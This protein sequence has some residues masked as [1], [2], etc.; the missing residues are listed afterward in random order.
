MNI[1]RKSNTSGALHIEGGN[2]SLNMRTN[3]Y[4]NLVT[5]SGGEF[6]VNTDAN[7]F[8]LPEGLVLTGGEES[9]LKFS[10]RSQRTVNANTFGQ[11]DLVVDVPF[12]GATLTI[13]NSNW[14]HTGAVTYIGS[15]NTDFNI[16]TSHDYT[17]STTIESA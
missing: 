4:D 5:M 14:S 7:L 12:G 15:G 13:S 9:R 1:N 6:F 10:S 16:D 8:I 2:I 3:R 11:G 17:G